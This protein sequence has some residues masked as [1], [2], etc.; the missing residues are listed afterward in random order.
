LFIWT[1]SAGTAQ[2][3]LLTPEDGGPPVALKSIGG[4]SLIPAAF[5]IRTDRDGNSWNVEADGNIG[6]I[7]SAMVNSGLML[8]IN[9]EKFTGVQPSM[10][11]DGREFVIH[12]MP[13]PS[14]PGVRVQRRVTM[15]E[16]SGGLCYAELFYNGSTD[17]VNLS[18]GLATNFSGNYKTFVSDRG[19]SEPVIPSSSESAL[20]VVPGTSESPK[21]FL[22]TFSNSESSVKPTISAQ[23]RYGLTYRFSL[24]LEPGESRIVVHHV[25][26][27]M[28]PQ[29]FDRRSLLK[30]SN[31]YRL[32]GI[33]SSLPAE[34]RRLIANIAPLPEE[35]QDS[36]LRHG[37]VES[38]GQLRGPR[39]I[40]VLGGETRLPGEVEENSFAV[41]TAYGDLEIKL[42]RVAAITEG[43]GSS[44][45]E[46]RIFLSDGQILTGTIKTPGL[47][48]AQAGGEKIRVEPGKFEH[49]IMAEV[50][51]GADWKTDSIALIET[52]GG[53]RIKV[54]NSGEFVLRFSTLWGDLTIGKEELIWLKPAGAGMPGFKVELR[55]G[56]R[57]YGVIAGEDI[58]FTATDY[59][60]IRLPPSALRHIFT[61][62][63]LRDES[64]QRS[65]QRVTV[66][67]LSGDQ[68]IVGTLS[69]DPF[70]V[71]TGGGTIKTAASEIRR[72]ARV[73]ASAVSN[74]VLPGD[75]PVF[76][77]ERWDGGLIKGGLMLETIPLQAAGITWQIPLRDVESLEIDSPLLTPEV[78]TQLAD[79]VLQLGAV[80]WA[81]RE[82]ATRELGAFGYLARPVLQRELGSNPDPEVERRIIRILED[83]N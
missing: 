52:T 45:S 73:D 80:D 39:D 46:S 53:D 57:C 58:F 18:V 25:A 82:A 41:S 47:T 74:G 83:L 79:L 4:E 30:L 78:A 44:K 40:L 77:I 76:E 34:W 29:T 17:A 75:S 10:S 54:N 62:T 42:D 23:N 2:E 63:H 36:A 28:I 14:L 27:V 66:N 81:A 1:S 48:F 20:I 6:R 12:G 71:I 69:A 68:Q 61:R 65:G 21:A 13:L 8:L 31:P 38:I 56:T 16:K 70:P 72:A 9:D 35:T 67:I 22:F 15:L 11:P 55:D 43:R 60:E 26:Q 37:G 32:D 3:P 24:P 5:G 19:R 51:S 64:I 7:G 50:E 33:V 49:L 59:G